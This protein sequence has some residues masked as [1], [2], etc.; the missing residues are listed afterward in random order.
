MVFIYPSFPLPLGNLWTKRRIMKIAKSW[1]HIYK[2]QRKFIAIYVCKGEAICHSLVTY[3][4][5]FSSLQPITMFLWKEWHQ[6]AQGCVGIYWHAQKLRGEIAHD[7]RIY[8]KLCR[9]SW[10]LLCAQ[11]LPLPLSSPPITLYIV[12]DIQSWE[13]LWYAWGD[14]TSITASFVRNMF[15]NFEEGSW[16]EPPPWVMTLHNFCNAH[17][18]M[19]VATFL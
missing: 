1:T 18:H 3:T 17:F 12:R 5:R 7:K 15:E 4:N 14:C 2:Q 9:S 6:S 13:V 8:N 16:N 19:Q 10:K 11:F